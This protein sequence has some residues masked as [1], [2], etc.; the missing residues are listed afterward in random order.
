VIH[1]DV[2]PANLLLS[3]DGL[4]KVSDF[5]VAT[6]MRRPR[7]F[8]AAS[9]PAGPPSL[10]GALVGTPEYMA[11]ELLLG[12]APDVRTDLYA[13]GMVLHECLTG[14]T[15]FPRDTPREFL[16][17]KLDPHLERPS[18]TIP[19]SEPP[20]LANLVAWMTAAAPADR[21]TS[22]ASVRALLLRLA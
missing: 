20:T 9:E 12:G 19:R 16:A 2:K 17:T 3:A 21:P 6:L 14:D 7:G 5:G 10:A 13:A 22:A 11:P 15:P 4:L 1:G 18:P 8:T